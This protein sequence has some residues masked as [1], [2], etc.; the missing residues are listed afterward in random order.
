MTKLLAPSLYATSE[1]CYFQTIT[2]DRNHPGRR[3]LYFDIEARGVGQLL[4]SPSV[5]KPYLPDAKMKRAMWWLQIPGND[6]LI[7]G[8]ILPFDL[9]GSVAT[10]AGLLELILERERV[11]WQNMGLRSR[12][13]TFSMSGDRR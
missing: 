6:F 4:F 3:L 13:L 7:L 2:A 1:T 8:G 12:S 10:V 9:D 11:R 5:R